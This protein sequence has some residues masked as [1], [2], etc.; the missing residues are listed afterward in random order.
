MKRKIAILLVIIGAGIA[1]SS[2]D[3]RAKKP[4][5]EQ[6]PI[7]DTLVEWCPAMEDSIYE[8]LI[9]RAT[10]MCKHLP[11]YDFIT[12]PL[13][14]SKEYMTEDFY[15]IIETLYNSPTPIDV[16]M[17]EWQNYFNT[18]KGGPISIFEVPIVAMVD[19]THAIA[20]IR[21]RPTWI[22]GTY[23]E[24]DE[25]EDHSLYLEW[26]GDNWLMSDFD[27]RKISCAIQIT[28]YWM[29]QIMRNAII[30]FIAKEIGPQYYNHPDEICIPEVVIIDIEY[31]DDS[32]VRVL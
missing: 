31:L 5:G 19:S 1:T 8:V 24:D 21:V 15:S 13:S 10:E 12:E 30:D 4:A 14:S 9:E 27:G 6:S 32:F 7:V 23:D 25:W 2:C 17:A 20:S 11:C 22:D 29:E 16:T 26:D 3:C 28:R 18:K